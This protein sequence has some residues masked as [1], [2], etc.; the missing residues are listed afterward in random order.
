[1]A[2]GKTSPTRYAKR[3]HG[4]VGLF[5]KDPHSEPN[6]ACS[7]PVRH[8]AWLWPRIR[9]LIRPKNRRGWPD[10][11]KFP[12]SFPV[13]RGIFACF[14]LWAGSILSPFCACSWRARG[15]NLRQRRSARGI[16]AKARRK[17]LGGHF[18]VYFF[19]CSRVSNDASKERSHGRGRSYFRAIF[20]ESERARCSA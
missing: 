16:S 12:V 20:S 5:L 15:A 3:M 6:P 1:V 8:V 13:S 14:S 18:V 10:S 7:L 2:G 19:G 9:A 11:T 4:T 17:S